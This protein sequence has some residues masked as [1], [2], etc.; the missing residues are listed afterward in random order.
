MSEASKA[1]ASAKPLAYDVVILGAGYAGLMAALRLGRRGPRRI[2]L[3]NC[4]GTISMANPGW[5]RSEGAFID[6][7][8]RGASFSGTTW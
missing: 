1:V 6:A 3:V 5:C 8:R 2:A 7:T 4:S